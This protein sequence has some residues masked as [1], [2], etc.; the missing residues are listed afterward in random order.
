MAKTANIN[1]RIEPETKQ[2][3][4]ALFAGFGITLSDAINIFLRKAI[5]DGGLPFDMRYGD[6]RPTADV[7]T[8][9]LQS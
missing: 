8:D 7:P 4:E 2:R 1:V 3:A 5:M 9:R 6:G